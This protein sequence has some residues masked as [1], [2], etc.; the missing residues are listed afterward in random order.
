MFLFVVEN[1]YENIPTMQINLQG[2]IIVS[3]YSDYEEK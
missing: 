3:K 1:R 2:L